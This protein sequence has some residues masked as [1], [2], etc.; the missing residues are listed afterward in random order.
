MDPTTVVCPQKTCPAS[1]HT[2]QGTIG[3]HAQQEQRC[4][5]HVCHQTFSATTGTACSRLRTS[6]EPVV[7]V[8]PLLAHGCPV[9]AIV[10]ALGFDERTVVAWWARAGRQG[11]AVPEYLGDFRERLYYVRV[12][13]QNCAFRSM[14]P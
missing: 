11:Q 4:I 9:L 14:K 6:T 3:I 10:A 8:V 1:G 12:I 2:G 7:L 13:V 5:C